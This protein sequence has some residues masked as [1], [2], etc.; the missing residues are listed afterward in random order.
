MNEKEQ[1][2][3]LVNSFYSKRDSLGLAFCVNW[4]NAVQCAKIAVQLIINAN[5]HSNPLNTEVESTMQYWLDVQRE[6]NKL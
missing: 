5:P 1:A 3:Q 4:S 2:E 6:I